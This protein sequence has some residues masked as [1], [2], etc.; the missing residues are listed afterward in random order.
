MAGTAGTGSAAR[1]PLD[2]A[3][4]AL[5]AAAMRSAVA[6]PEREVRRWFVFGAGPL[7]SMIQEG[8]IRRLQSGRCSHLMITD[9]IRVRPTLLTY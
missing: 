4:R 9:E 5:L 8:L 3:E 6:A 1:L 2:E 7:D